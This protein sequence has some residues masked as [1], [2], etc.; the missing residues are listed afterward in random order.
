MGRAPRGIGGR[1]HI[2]VS[3]E[4]DWA[5]LVWPNRDDGVLQWLCR[6]R[7]YARA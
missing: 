4:E 7:A 5:A 2:T 3:A 6:Q 1:Q